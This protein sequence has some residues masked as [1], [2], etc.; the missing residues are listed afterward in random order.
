MS[1]YWPML[2]TYGHRDVGALEEVDAAFARAGRKVR[3]LRAIEA[4]R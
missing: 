3:H 4:M 2:E 1:Q